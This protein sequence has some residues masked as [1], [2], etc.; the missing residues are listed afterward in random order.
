[1]KPG[2]WVLGLVLGA[3]VLLGCGGAARAPLTAEAVVAS[4]RGSGLPVTEVREFTA[5]SDPNKLLGRPGQYTLKVSW[6]DTRA[7]GEG[8]DATVEV[9][10]T[11]EALAQ[12]K[13]YTKAIADTGGFF[14]QYIETNDGRLALLRLPH[15]LTPEQA[16]PYRDWL[17]AL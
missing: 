7:A 15:Q 8:Q 1:M 14:A 17:A 5:E 10:A 9:F 16:K 2:A 12:R 3:W 6:Q 4:L 11:A 13:A